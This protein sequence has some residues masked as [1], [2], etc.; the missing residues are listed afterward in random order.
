MQFTHTILLVFLIALLA[1]CDIW[2]G[3]NR[4]ANVA[5][6]PEP[7]RVGAVI[8]NTPGVDEVR[9]RKQKGGRSVT[10]TGLKQADQIHI[11]N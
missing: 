10:L 4:R 2:H 6:M 7:A 5:F 9:Y 1:G 3:V 8:R 11:F